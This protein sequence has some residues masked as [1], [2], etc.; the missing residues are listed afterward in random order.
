MLA[1]MTETKLEATCVVCGG[2]PLLS[3]RAYRP[4]T[5]LFWRSSVA[6][7]RVCDL[8]QVVP[9]PTLDELDAYYHKE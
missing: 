7:C 6:R 3:E 9:M 4:R 1:Q 5:G 2:T 8:R